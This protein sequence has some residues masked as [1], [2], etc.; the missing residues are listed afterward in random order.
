MVKSNR[1]GQ[2]ATLSPEQLDSIAEELPP[3]PRAVFS[4]CRFTAARV[5]EALKLRWENIM[6][7][8]VIIPKTITKKKMKT[9][10]IDMNPRLW[11]ELANWKQ[12]WRDVQNREPEKGDYVFPNAKDPKTH[13][14]RQ[15]V[16]KALRGVCADLDVVGASTHSLRRSA[17]T[18]ASDKGV[19]LRVLQSISGHSSL[20]MLQRYLDVKAE[21][22]RAAVMAFG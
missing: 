13:M 5:S 8:E 12:R 9:R 15:A 4:V 20:E 6:Q 16:D 1:N 21:A 11:E 2:A 14:T 3:A 22:R 18:A 17:L 10:A 7:S 19:P